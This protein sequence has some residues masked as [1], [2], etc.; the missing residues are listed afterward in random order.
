MVS[1]HIPLKH[2]FPFGL[3]IL[4]RLKLTCVLIE[5]V[6]GG[7]PGFVATDGTDWVDNGLVERVGVV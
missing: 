6:L 4:S 5:R 3:K 1:R 2:I 7:A